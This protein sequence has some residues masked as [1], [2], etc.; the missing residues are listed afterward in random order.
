MMRPVGTVVTGLLLELRQ[1]ARSGFYAAYAVLTVMFVVIIALLPG[2]ARETGLRLIVLMDPGFMGFFF[3]GGLVLLER[4]QG[5]LSVIQTHGRGFAGYWGSK[6]GAI[7]LLALSVVLL[8]LGVSGWLGFVRLSLAGTGLLLLGVV[9]TVPLFYSIGLGIAGLCPRILEYF[10]GA[11]IGMLPLLFPVVELAGLSVGWFGVL[12]PL[13]GGMVLVLPD[14][15]S[16]LELIVAV[17]SLVVWNVVAFSVA[18]RAFARLASGRAG[19]GLAGRLWGL[20]RG[21]LRTAGTAGT[22]AA[23]AAARRS[24]G[25]RSREAVLSPS[26]ADILLLLRDPVHVALLLAPVLAA[27]ALGRGVPYLLAD[28]SPAAAVIP[29]AVGTAVLPVMDNLRSFALLLGAVMYGMIGAFLMLD[30]KD[31]GVLPFLRTLP[32][33]PGWHV[34]RRAGFLLVAWVVVLPLVVWAGDLYHGGGVAFALSLLMD[35]LVLLMVFT[36]ISIVAANKVQG[37]A[38]AKMGNISTLPPLLCIALPGS[39]GWLLAVLPTAW[40]SML[41]LQ[42]VSWLQAVAVAFVGGVYNAGLLLLLYRRA[43][44]M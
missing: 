11:S 1:Q 25:G 15:R 38:L 42:E 35:A 21:R 44:R 18:G 4:D 9:L 36:G 39:W 29:A 34:L 7:L 32:G 37:L 27:A 6:V 23:G 17:A 20:L 3:A 33:R 26:A 22:G 14:G 16:W 28:G 43:R 19:A 13:W 41:R 24:R 8:L 12:S 2:A 31:E 30:E 5:V 40:G 10:V